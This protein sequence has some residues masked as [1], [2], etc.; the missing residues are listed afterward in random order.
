M[1]RAAATTGQCGKVTWS[2]PSTSHGSAVFFFFFCVLPRTTRG[3]G[4]RYACAAYPDD[5]GR[6][7]GADRQARRWRKRAR[8]MAVAKGGFPPSP[9]T[10][11]PGPPE[12]GRG[13]SQPGGRACDTS[14]SG[15]RTSGPGVSDP[16]EEFAKLIDVARPTLRGKDT[17]LRRTGTYAAVAGFHTGGCRWACSGQGCATAAP[18]PTRSAWPSSSP[19]PAGH[20]RGLPGRADYMP[21]EELPAVR[22]RSCGPQ[23]Y[24]GRRRPKIVDPVVFESQRAREWYFERAAVIAMLD[25][26]SAGCTGPWTRIYFRLLGRTCLRPGAGA[27]APVS[28][29]RPEGMVAGQ[30]MAAARCAPR[31]PRSATTAGGRDER[32]SGQPVPRARLEPG[33]MWW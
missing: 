32:R 22:R 20:P 13:G 8:I 33:R 30:V 26:R 16:V 6:H 28:L 14:D 29:H 11:A 31:P 2:Q 23:G 3:P 21:D 15:P 18:L 7:D 9:G 25:R 5:M 17:P 10:A 1:G 24:A 19:H 27:A 12:P 4:P